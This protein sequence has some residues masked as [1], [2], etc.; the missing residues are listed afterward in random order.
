MI[1]TADY[2]TGSTV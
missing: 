2:K 1:Y